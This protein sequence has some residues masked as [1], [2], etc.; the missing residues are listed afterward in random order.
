[1][2]LTAP[3]PPEVGDAVRLINVLGSEIDRLQNVDPETAQFIGSRLE[4][5]PGFAA[6]SLFDHPDDSG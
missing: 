1:V 4:Q 3:D 5:I 2:L 6:A